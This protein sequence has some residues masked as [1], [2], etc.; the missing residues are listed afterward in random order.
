MY[1]NWSKIDPMKLHQNKVMSKDSIKALFVSIITKIIK[2]VE[3]TTLNVIRVGS[4]PTRSDVK[5]LIRRPLIVNEMGVMTPPSTASQ[6]GTLC[7]R[8][9]TSSSFE[10]NE[11]IT[12]LM[13]IESI[14]II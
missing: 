4:K 9:W 12:V 2:L 5:C 6:T 13:K 8:R 10:S 11:M 7:F 3:R 1:P 14:P